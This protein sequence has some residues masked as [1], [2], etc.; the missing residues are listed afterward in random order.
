LSFAF[1]STTQPCYFFVEV[2]LWL[3][4]ET[5]TENEKFHEDPKCCVVEEEFVTWK[6]MISGIC[7]QRIGLNSVRIFSIRLEST[8][9]PIS[10]AST[11]HSKMQSDKR[12]QPVNEI[13]QSLLDKSDV[14]HSP[15]FSIKGQSKEGR[16]AYLDFQATTPLDP[17]VLDA[18]VS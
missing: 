16:P 4:E 7:R 18:M 5:R 13:P 15:G 6:R 11:P 9:V 17:R 10:H 3:L 12:Y 1:D 8:T 14:I 2:N